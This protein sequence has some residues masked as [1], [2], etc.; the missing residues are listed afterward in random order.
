MKNGRPLETAYH[1]DPATGDLLKID[2]SDDTADVIFAYDRLGRKIRVSDAAGVHHFAYND[3]LQLK[4]EG[5]VGQQIYQINRYYDDLGRMSGFELD[6]EYKVSYGYDGKGRFSTV[7]WRTGTETGGVAYRYLAQ[8]DRLAGMESKGGLSVSYDYEPHRDVKIAVTNRFNDRLISRYAYEYD[9]LGRRINAKSTGEAFETPGFWLYGYNDRNEVTAAS[10]F[11]GEDLKVQTQPMPELER[12]YQYDPIGNRITAV[13]G[14]TELHYRANNLNQYETISSSQVGNER[15]SYDADGNLIEDGRYRY[16]WN[17]EN[18]L[19]AVEP[20]T[21][22]K[23]AKRLEFAY[24]YLGRRFIKKVLV[25]E[26]T[27]FVPSETIYFV[28]DGWNMIRETK[29]EEA[30]CID[31]FYVW[32]LDL[33]QSLQGVGGVG[34]VLEASD[35]SVKYSYLFDAT[36]NVTQVIDKGRRKIDI[37]YEYF[38]FSEIIRRFDISAKNNNFRFSNKF[39]DNE[40]DLLYYGYRYYKPGLEK[41]INRDP[42]GQK[43]GFNVYSFVDNNSINTVDINGLYGIDVHYGLTFYLAMNAGLCMQDAEKFASDDQSVDEGETNPFDNYIENVGTDKLREAMQAHF[44]ID[45][46]APEGTTVERNSAYVYKLMTTAFRSGHT[47]LVGQTLHTFQD[48]WAHEGF[49][50]Q[51][52]LD[53]ST[54]KTYIKERWEKRDLEMARYTYSMLLIMIDIKNSHTRNFNFCICRKPAQFPEEFVKKYL[55]ADS[56]QEKKYLLNNSKFKINI[57]KF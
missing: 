8:S 47:E 54:D 56:I 34:G 17:A 30:N 41:W 12:G 40:I 4:S 25:F 9:P 3:S 26:G 13:E 57:S 46:N 53:A 43:G 39:Y 32:G 16:R 11:V 44:P 38:P 48:S 22:L 20:K 55:K 28:Y 6:D 19:V 29:T 49:V 24:D 52:I 45:P 23:G 7:D 27:R 1:Y 50:N 33:S 37:N 31:R 42:L 10:R 14:N 2:Y 36:G 51:H 15:F 35:D 18:R 5:L 21:F